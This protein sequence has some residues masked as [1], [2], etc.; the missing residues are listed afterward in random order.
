M[1]A[2]EQRW[3]RDG[4]GAFSFA[5]LD[6]VPDLVACVA[7]D[8]SLIYTNRSFED[9]TSCAFL[10]DAGRSLADLRPFGDA[11][12]EVVA[13]IEEA[14]DAWGRDSAEGEIHWQVSS[15]VDRWFVIRAR[16]E[17][18]PAQAIRRVVVTAREIT[19]FRRTER[20][21][22]EREA[23]FRALVENTPDN[24]VRYDADG[25][26]TYCNQEIALSTDLDAREI[27]GKRPTESAASFMTGIEE[28]ERVLMRTLATGD[29]GHAE[30][31]FSRG[32]RGGD[33]SVHSILF[34]AERDETGAVVGALAVGR[35]V[36]ELIESRQ[37]AREGEREF[38]TLAENAEDQ[39]ARWDV[40]ER[41]TYANPRM[42]GMLGK[43]AEEVIGEHAFTT[44]LG[45]DMV[46]REAVRRILDGGPAET[47]EAAFFDPREGTHRVHEIRFVP[48]HDD[49]GRLIG[50]LG[51]GR[52]ITDSVRVR[53]DLDRLA[54]T[55][56]LTGL[57]NSQAFHEQAPRMLASA[58]RAGHE[59]AILLLDLDGFK[60]VNDTLGHAGGDRVLQAVA[61]S[62]ARRLRPYDLFARLGGDEFAILIE[63]IGHEHDL[64]AITAK[65]QRAL[66]ERVT[67]HGTGIRASIGVA[68][69]PEDGET[70]EELVQHADMAM[71]QAKRTAHS[72]VEY[73]RPELAETLGR[74]TTIEKALEGA[75]LFAQLSVHMQPI[76]TLSVEWGPTYAEALLRWR[77]PTLGD[78]S[79]A[80]F[81]PIAEEMGAIGRIGRW[82]LEQA[83]AAVVAWNAG[84]PES[85]TIAVSVNVSTSQ[86]ALDDMDLAVEAALAATGCRP[87]W[88]VLEIT[89]SLLLED[90]DAVQGALTRLRARGVR[91]AI[92]DFGTGYSALHYLARFPLDALKIDRSFVSGLGLDSEHDEVVNAL[93]A[94]ARVL[95]LRVVAEGVETQEQLEIVS[96]FGVDHV[97]GFLLGRPTPVELFAE[98]FLQ[99]AG[100]S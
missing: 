34:T 52:D 98:A 99:D 4:L 76:H 68:L 26:A 97:Q 41:Y 83:A 85:R 24:I 51:I 72:A 73:F 40:D 84:R 17:R 62:V 56:A 96:R 100:R 31:V 19:R 42:L 11:T 59:A 78:V 29:R 82:V 81:I 32:D 53:E 88:L 8:L 86:F 45:G 43:P 89:E 91:I 79:P 1:D 95:R 60:A 5:W 75:D 48:E 58:S 69:F 64:G 71:Y 87:E 46:G 94:L 36:T 90:S 38:R 61:D 67:D 65:I 92:D 10:D 66:S 25:I 28:Y 39:I 80:E 54:H 12:A 30:L 16:A 15:L 22:R 23:E 21:L 35:D 70:V 44:A 13:L 20:A 93:I 33:Q 3:D 47:I 74:R 27:I 57:A 50:V 9:A 77:H 2:R 6:A 18:D 37:R 55:D 63:D 49:A 7:P 14:R